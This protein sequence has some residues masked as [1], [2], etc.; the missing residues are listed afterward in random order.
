[1]PIKLGIT[2]GIGSGKSMVSHLLEVIGVP[3]YI[4][5]TESKRL[6]TTDPQIRRELIDLL[7]EKV[8]QN[9]ELNKPFLANYLF[10]DP[11]HA[12][13]VNSIIHPKVKED[14][15]QWAEA[16]RQSPIIAMEAA[17]LIE[18]G[19]ADQI[20]YIVMVY[21]PEELRI[22]RAIKRDDSN[23]EA[24]I[25]RIQSQMSDE[26]KKAK[27]HY[28]I[29]NDNTQSIISQIEHLLNTLRTK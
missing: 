8:Y 7:G 26:E 11:E 14:F 4:A 16:H 15:R 9:G 27:A 24:I 1:M 17:I 23:R 18:A 10:S 12:R 22:E 19:F 2:G 21:A 25:R 28:T 13:K 6:T 20:D 3:V 5:D 29:V